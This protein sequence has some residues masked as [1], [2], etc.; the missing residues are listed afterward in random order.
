MSTEFSYDPATGQRGAGCPAP[1]AGQ[2]SWTGPGY[3]WQPSAT[4]QDPHDVPFDTGP[5]EP[6]PLPENIQAG[7]LGPIS[8]SRQ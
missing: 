5:F 6:G 4:E 1:G 8:Q 7:P 3:D 2:P